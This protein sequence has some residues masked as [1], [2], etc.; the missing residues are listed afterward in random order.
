MMRDT[1][2]HRSEFRQS[3]A[4]PY[5][6]VRDGL[7]YVLVTTNRGKWIFPKGVVEPTL[8][9][10]ESALKEAYEEAGVIGCIEPISVGSYVY[11]K[12]GN[13][14]TV[15][16]YPFRIVKILDDWEDAGNRKRRIVDYRK[17]R[18][19]INSSLLGVLGAAQQRLVGV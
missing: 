13:R 14:Y 8:E 5:L 12:R 9:P 4:I 16:M 2:N 1:D 6:A 15:D 3:G 7:R 17:A 11:K 18:K 10:W 19:L